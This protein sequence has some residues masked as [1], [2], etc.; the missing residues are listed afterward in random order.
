MGTEHK[1]FMH[2]KDLAMHQQEYGCR[3]CEL[4]LRERERER[5]R[6]EAVLG[7]AGLGG[8]LACVWLVAWLAGWP[9]LAA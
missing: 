5:E 1:A 7:W 3:Q 9:G 2:N 6:A 8:W 4:F